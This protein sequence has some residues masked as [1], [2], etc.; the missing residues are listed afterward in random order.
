MERTPFFLLKELPP[1]NQITFE[2]ELFHFAAQM[3]LRLF[4]TFKFRLGRV[5]SD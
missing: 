3:V 4:C 1:V 5:I 2:R